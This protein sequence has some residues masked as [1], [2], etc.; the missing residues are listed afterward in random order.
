MRDWQTIM[1]ENAAMVL[2]KWCCWEK[3]EGGFEAMVGEE[4]K[5]FHKTRGMAI[6]PPRLTA[7]GL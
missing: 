5:R 2:G 7:L 6:L 3:V 4:E 1:T